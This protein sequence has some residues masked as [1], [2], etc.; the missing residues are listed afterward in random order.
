MSN[1]HE[2]NTFESIKLDLTFD[3]VA[4]LETALLRLQMHYEDCQGE[5]KPEGIHYISYNRKVAAVQRLA[6]KIKG[7]YCNKPSEA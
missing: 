6:K 2:T 5:H 7:Q 1:N 3:E 4:D